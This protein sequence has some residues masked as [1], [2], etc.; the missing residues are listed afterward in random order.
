MTYSEWIR[1][2]ISLLHRG[3]IRHDVRVKFENL[4]RWEHSL[5]AYHYATI[6]QQWSG[7]TE[8]V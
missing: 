6:G 3:Q 1:I 5:E 2:S 7:T 4:S 8:C